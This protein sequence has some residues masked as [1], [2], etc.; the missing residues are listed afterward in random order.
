M[1]ERKLSPV[2]ITPSFLQ[3]THLSFRDTIQILS[4]GS[5]LK[6][7]NMDYRHHFMVIRQSQGHLL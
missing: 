4:S 1:S 6:T 2:V 5:S 3:I 7:T